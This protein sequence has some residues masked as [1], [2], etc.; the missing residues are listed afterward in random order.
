MGVNN[1]KR[2]GGGGFSDLPTHA[3]QV[4]AHDLGAGEKGWAFRNN[5]QREEQVSG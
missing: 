4:G 1:G 2:D 3:D 5:I